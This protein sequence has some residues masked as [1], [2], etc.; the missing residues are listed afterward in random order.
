MT[1]RQKRITAIKIQYANKYEC[2]NC[3]V[4]SIATVPQ[5]YSDAPPPG[6]ATYPV[7]I[8]YEC[9]DPQIGNTFVHTADLDIC[10][11]CAKLPYESVIRKVIERDKARRRCI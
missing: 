8:R 5:N 10:P 1:I 4:V 2:D 11:D 6:W 9:K 3:G 7:Q